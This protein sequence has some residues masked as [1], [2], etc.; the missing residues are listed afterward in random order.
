M[1]GKAN[2]KFALIDGKFIDVEHLDLPM[3]QDIVR[4]TNPFEAS[5]TVISK[6]LDV[7]SLRAIDSYVATKRSTMTETEAVHLYPKIKEFVQQ[8]NRSPQLNH[9]DHLE[10]RLALALGLIVER[11]RLRL[12]EQADNQ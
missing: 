9:S 4:G 8:Y 12:Q 3:I 10:N 7:N 1:L 2:K 6:K 5:Y 11:Q